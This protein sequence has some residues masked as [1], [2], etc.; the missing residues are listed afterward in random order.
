MSAA[1][2]QPTCPANVRPPPFPALQPDGAG[3]VLPEEAPL[4][5]V[6]AKHRRAPVARLLR[7]D[8]LGD[9]GSGS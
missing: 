1:R 4:P 6:P 9:P 2:W 7:D 8:A 5:D 3:G